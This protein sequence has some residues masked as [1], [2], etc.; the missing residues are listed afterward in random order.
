MPRFFVEG[1]APEPGDRITLS[2]E[3]SRHVSL[4]LRM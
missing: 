3:D 4:S 2:E 1:I